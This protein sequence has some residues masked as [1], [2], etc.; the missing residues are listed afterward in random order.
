[1]KG[2]G[3]LG[4][5]P[6]IPNHRAPNQQ[7]TITLPET[8][9]SPLKIGLPKRKIVF[10]PSIFRCELL[11]SGRVTISW[12]YLYKIL[13]HICT[14]N[15]RR[16]PPCSAWAICE[17]TV[18]WIASGVR[19]FSETVG[20]CAFFCCW[21]RW[22][23]MWPW[24]SLCN[25]CIYDNYNDN[26]SKIWDFCGFISICVHD[27]LLFIKNMLKWYY[28]KITELPYLTV[29]HVDQ[30]IIRSDPCD[31]SMFLLDPPLGLQWNQNLGWLGYIGDEISY[32]IIWGL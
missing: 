28:K 18:Q 21:F 7:L 29:V 5:T 26:I 14:T 9:S 6:R 2:I 30:P 10:Q 20:C 17:W 27:E 4:C 13:H 19:R 1:M 31:A 11:V 8:N 16:S 24:Y 12:Y 23:F 32:P 25:L 22:V 15:F 3:I